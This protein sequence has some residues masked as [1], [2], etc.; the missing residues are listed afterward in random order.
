MKLS[1]SLTLACS[2]AAL[3]IATGASAQQYKFVATDNSP[4]TKLCV[5]AGSNEKFQLKRTAKRYHLGK[6][7]QI[8]NDFQCN[9]L[10]M[11]Q[12]AYKYN[13]SDT[14]ELLERYSHQENKVGPSVTIH[15]VA[16]NTDVKDPMIIYVSTKN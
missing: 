1:Y 14:Y 8:A 12:F 5:K 13:A 10:S 15:D 16:K 6:M 9:G 4:A 3:F 2:L 11:A 7:A